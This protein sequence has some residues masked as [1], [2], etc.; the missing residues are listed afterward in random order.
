[1][2]RSCHCSYSCSLKPPSTLSWPLPPTGHFYSRQPQRWSSAPA[3]LKGSLHPAPEATM[4]SITHEPPQPSLIWPW[5]G[6][7]VQGQATWRIPHTRPSCLP[8]SQDSAASLI[9]SNP[10]N[11]ETSTLLPSWKASEFPQVGL[12]HPELEIPCP[13]PGHPGQG[14]QSPGCLSWKGKGELSSLCFG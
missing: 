11:T 6:R 8:N 14:T 10:Q 7:Q 12:T 4:V 9:L 2:C 13:G 1:M 5:L 3:S